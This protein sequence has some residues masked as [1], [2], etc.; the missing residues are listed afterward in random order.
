MN[1]EK[2]IHHLEHLREKHAKLDKQV[3]RM[4]FTGHFVDAE[5]TQLKKQRLAIRDEMEMVFDKINS[6]ENAA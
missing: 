2:L 5:L 6:F 4:E 1:K 3:D